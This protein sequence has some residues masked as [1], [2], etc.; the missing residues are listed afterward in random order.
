MDFTGSSI[1]RVGGGGGGG[2]AGTV[3]SGA[4]FG[5]YAGR[6]Y[7]V[8]VEQVDFNPQGYFNLTISEIKSLDPATCPTVP[9]IDIPSEVVNTFPTASFA[10]GADK[11][12]LYS[13]IPQMDTLAVVRWKVGVLGFNPVYIFGPVHCSGYQFNESYAL[14]PRRNPWEATPMSLFS[15]MT[16]ATLLKGKLYYIGVRNVTG[17]EENGFRFQIMGSFASFNVA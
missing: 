17:L 7:Y 11:Y 16:S 14:A 12:T 9:S 2:S 4:L 8:A 1:L 15:D 6:T 10:Y 13:V 5:V 3:K